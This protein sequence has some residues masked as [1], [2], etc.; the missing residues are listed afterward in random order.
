MRELGGRQDKN[1]K[2][3][4]KAL[5]ENWTPELKLIEFEN[6]KVECGELLKP[7]RG[8]KKRWAEEV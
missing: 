2:D 5:A 6:D 8:R 3:T 1:L 4:A 7:A